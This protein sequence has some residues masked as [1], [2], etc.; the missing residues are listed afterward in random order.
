MRPP[1][2]AYTSIAPHKFINIIRWCIKHGHPTNAGSATSNPSTVLPDQVP[3]SHPENFFR[4]YDMMN[5]NILKN[6]YGPP[7][8]DNDIFDRIGETADKWSWTQTR[9]RILSD[10]M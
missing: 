3:L 5:S 9:P 4:V 7:F 6:T 1:Y 10:Q 2:I 8:N